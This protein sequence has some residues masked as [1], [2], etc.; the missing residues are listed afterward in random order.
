MKNG[1]LPIWETA[2]CQSRNAG[3][4]RDTTRY[5]MICCYARGCAPSNEEGVGSLWGLRFTTIS[6]QNFF[7][8]YMGNPSITL[9]VTLTAVAL[10]TLCRLKVRLGGSTR[11]MQDFVAGR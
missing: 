8:I 6:P 2:R 11:Y 7:K 5:D 3:N 4:F 10:I 1:P 9:L